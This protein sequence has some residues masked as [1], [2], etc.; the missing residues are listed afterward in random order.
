M[1]LQYLH[2][3]IPGNRHSATSISKNIFKKSLQK[4]FQSFQENAPSVSASCQWGLMAG[5]GTVFPS[6]RQRQ[7]CSRWS[8]SFVLCKGRSIKVCLDYCCLLFIQII[9]PHCQDVSSREALL[10]RRKGGEPAAL[11]H[12]SG[13]YV[14]FSDLDFSQKKIIFSGGSRLP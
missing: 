4:H 14:L 13:C 1:Q 8:S 11:S 12:Y 10:G 6:S 5:Q 7:H 3:G 2:C 9:L